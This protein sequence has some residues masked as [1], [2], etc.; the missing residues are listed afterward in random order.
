MNFQAYFPP[1]L[2]TIFNQDQSGGSQHTEWLVPGSKAGGPPT[3]VEV[4]TG[5]F[6]IRV[7]ATAAGQATRSP[8]SWQLRLRDLGDPRLQLTDDIIVAI[9]VTDGVY[10]AYCHD[11]DDF[12]TGSSEADV[13]ADFKASAVDLYFLLKESGEPNL[14]PLPL[15]HWRFLKRIIREL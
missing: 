7:S 14:G 12:G 2:T 8:A 6:S 4:V 5:R 13:L 3:P 1:V 15:A 11:L 10:T 9:D